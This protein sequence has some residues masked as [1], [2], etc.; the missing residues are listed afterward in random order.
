MDKGIY[1]SV[2]EEKFGSKRQYRIEGVYA[3]PIVGREY[4]RAL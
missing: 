3:K 1:D 2:L 4:E